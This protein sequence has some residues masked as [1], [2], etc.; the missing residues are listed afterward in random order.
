MILADR[1]LA[2]LRRRIGFVPTGWSLVRITLVV[3]VALFVAGFIVSPRPGNLS[4]APYNKAFASTEVRNVALPLGDPRGFDPTPN[5]NSFK[6]AWIGGSETLGVG[7]KTGAFIP[8]LVSEQIGSVKGKKV[9]TD[10]YFLNAI[11]VAD[12]LA[13]LSSA[14]ASKPDLVVISLNPVWVLNDVAAQQWSYLDGALARQSVWPPSRWV[15]GASLLSPGDVGWQVL[16]AVSPPLISDRFE[17]GRD[18]AEQTSGLSFLDVVMDAQPPPP[19]ELGRLAS[20]RPVDFWFSRFKASHPGTSLP[21]QQLSLLE[22]EIASPSELNDAVVRQMFEMVR[23]AGVDTYVYVHAIDPKVYAKPDAKR[24]ISQLRAKLAE[25][26]KGETSAHI[27][28]DPEGLQDRVAPTKYR[29]IVHVRD[30][31]NEAAVL[32]TDLCALLRSMG[33]QPTC[34]AP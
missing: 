6:I 16:S 20:R 3:I 27:V 13:A 26:T 8:R 19:T 4:T 18:V 5:G 29:D 21:E 2:F 30:G 10:I 9:S 32:T 34:G 11:R 12:E 22:R 31:R 17:W 24:Y 15:V 23:S 14:L 28:F 7:P 25:L 1:F 33:R